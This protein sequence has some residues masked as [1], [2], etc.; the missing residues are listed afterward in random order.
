LLVGL[1]LDPLRAF[2]RVAAIVK[3][4]EPWASEHSIPKTAHRRMRVLHGTGT[5]WLRTKR[6][7]PKEA[8]NR[9]MFEGDAR[10]ATEDLRGVVT[11]GCL[12]QESVKY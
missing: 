12:I 1:F 8:W 7:P 4:A 3:R 10:G 5:V 2:L 6:Q 9:E 11:F